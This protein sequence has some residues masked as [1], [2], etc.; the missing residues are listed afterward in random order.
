MR[1]VVF[2]CDG[3]LI[4]SK[5]ATSSVIRDVWRSKGLL[6]PEE[7]AMLDGHVNASLED[8]ISHLYKGEDRSLKRELLAICK[9]KLGIIEHEAPLFE[10]ASKTLK[11]LKD[12]GDLCAI[13]TAKGRDGLQRVLR[14]HNLEKF[15]AVTKTVESGPRKPDP[16]LLLEAMQDVGAQSRQTIFIGDTIFDMQMASRAGVKS[17]GVSFGYHSVSALKASGA[18]IIVNTFDVMIAAIDQLFMDRPSSGT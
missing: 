18:S 11:S 14:H 16:T 15:F 6:L 12:R 5:G 17:I 4:D 2:D 10:G 7:V 9:V 1:F 3:T 8:L 13:V